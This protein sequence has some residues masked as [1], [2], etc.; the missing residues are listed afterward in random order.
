MGKFINW[1]KKKLRGSSSQGN[2]SPAPENPD[3]ME[4]IKRIDE[5]TLSELRTASVSIGGPIIPRYENLLKNRN[6]FKYWQAVVKAIC[7]AESNFNPR[8]RFFE[9]SMGYYSEGLMQLSYEDCRAYGFPLNKI[10]NEIFDIE[11]NIQL[12]MI[13]LDRLVKNHGKF[14]FNS[15]NYWAVLQPKNKRHSVFLKKF[16]EYYQGEI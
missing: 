1:I 7:F 14:I 12:G 9:D 8:E 2:S 10:K 4:V 13:I 16:H 15:G 3:K 6:D 11:K 5:V